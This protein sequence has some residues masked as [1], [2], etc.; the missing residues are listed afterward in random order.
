MAQ[1]TVQGAD[2]S[3][4]NGGAVQFVLTPHGVSNGQFRVD[5][6]VSTHSGDLAQLDLQSATE[7]R[8][9]DQVLRP[10]ESVALRGHHARGRMAFALQK[11]PQQFEIV[12]RGVR[13]MDDLSFRWP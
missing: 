4:S 3:R 12:I 9:A 6:Q 2:T 11:A 10:L 5:V 7:L 1:S 13:G 8:V